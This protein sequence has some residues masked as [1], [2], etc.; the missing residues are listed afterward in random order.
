MAH[1]NG[2]LA[3]LPPG[4]ASA[5]VHLLPEPSA[6]SPERLRVV[7]DA[8]YAGRVAVTYERKKNHRFCTWFWVPCRADRVADD[9]PL[10]LS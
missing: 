5:G 7:F 1:D 8:E 2:I 9:T 3:S 4:N 10:G 6:T